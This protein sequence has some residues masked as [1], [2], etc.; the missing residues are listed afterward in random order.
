MNLTTD[1]WV[2]IVWSDGKPGM[3]SLLEAFERGAEIQDLG[4]RPHERI[5]TMRLLICIAQAALD[6]PRDFE[7]WKSCRPRIVTS[8]V[9]YLSHARQAFELFGERQRFLQI[10]G[11][12]KPASTSDVD[13]EDEGNSTSKLDPALATGNNS[14]LF[15]NAGGVARD[16]T[17]G[18]LA[19][20][21]LTF[22]CFSPGGRIGIALWDGQQTP[23]NGSSD[24]AP[25]LAGG[26]LHTLL[27]GDSLISTVHRNLLNK[28]LSD[29]LF[30]EA[31]WGK[32]V[33]ELMPQRITDTPAV[34]NATHTYLGRL[35]PLSRA[36]YLADNCRSLI[37]ANGL[38]Y[39]SYENGW[40]EPCAT[41]I[42]RTV[43]KQP[44][45]A[46]LPA[47]I[48]KA[49]WRELYALTVKGVGQGPGGPAALQNIPE[50]ADAFDLWVG[51]LV[52]T[53][54]KLVDTTE[55]VFHIPGTMLIAPGQ[56]VYENGVKDAEMVAS[57]LTRAIRV[58]HIALGDNLDR[59]EMKDRRQQIQSNAAAQFW[60]DIEQAVPLLLDAAESGGFGPKGEWRKTA[61][62]QSVR[63]SARSA[64]EHACPHE[65]ARQIR[66]YA[67]GL[68][69]FFAARRGPAEAK[70]EAEQ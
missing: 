34:R 7:D 36:V 26:M 5:A 9:A 61:W 3:V 66:A 40:R 63:R 12:K 13:R 17:P 19:L 1:A 52:A 41:I 64:F 45:P 68:N 67:L 35:V 25:C 21:L 2:P 49:A 39:P 58:Y 8:A 57:R 31:S 48:E 23:G 28:R 69:A 15:D 11:L 30:K 37:L 59:P 60:T 20:M 62:G 46:V 55:S 51:G 6:G 32:P 18:Q 70:E 50:N 42:I 29:Q 14:T 24:H 22:Q 27:R 10:V 56:R 53:Q 16:F 54:A 4:L 38:E 47:S 65:T 44:T 33:W 43:Q